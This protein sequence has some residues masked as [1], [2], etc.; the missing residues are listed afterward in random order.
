MIVVIGAGLAGLT[1]A[2]HLAEAGVDVTLCEAHP[3]FLGGRTR[4]R[5]PYRFEWRGATHA[6]SLD[7]GQH[8]MWFQYYNMRRLLVRLGLWESS[9]RECGATRYIV[10]DGTEVV[11]LPPLDVRP[12]NA[13]ASRLEFLRDLGRATGVS[14]PGLA[15]VGRL[16]AALPRL[17]QLATFRHHRDYRRWDEVSVSQ[18]FAWIGLPAN[19]DQIFKSL[20]KASTFHRHTEISAAWGLSMAESTLMHDPRDHKMWC[21]RGNLGTHLIDPLAAA[22]RARGGRLLRNARAVDFDVTDGRLTAVHLA[23]TSAGPAP[24]VRGA[25]D[26][27]PALTERQ[28]LACDAVVSATDIPGAQRLMLPRFGERDDLRSIANLDTVANATI[29]VVTSRRIRDGE[30]WMGILSGRFVWLDCYFLLSRYQD[31]FMAWSEATGGEVIEFHSYF[32]QREVAA[33]GPE[34]VRESVEKEVVRVW[35]E[36]TG[37]IVHIEHFV[38][39]QTFDKQ[40]VGHHGFFPPM[41]TSVP[42]LTLCGSWPRIDSAVHDMEKAVLTGILAA[43]R[44]LAEQGR[45][46]T[47]IIP[48]RPGRF[49]S[50]AARVAASVLPRPDGVRGR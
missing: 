50:V 48:L 21:F 35:P 9:V 25:G 47:P 37:A 5:D 19:M 45:P 16:A 22:V 23:P 46:L 49:S 4:P 11:R 1:A 40:T 12:T 43:N 2:F 24:V 27:V 20:C 44:I 13:A 38:N 39:E 6:H 31:E 32:A 26:L 17:L 30:P 3:A 14:L 15:D 34:T 29:R 41:R 8:C 42:N 33:C 18:M 36:L 10:D 7:H 28:S